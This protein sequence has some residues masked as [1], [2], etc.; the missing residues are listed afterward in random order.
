MRSLL[1]RLRPRLI[2]RAGMLLA[3][4]LLLGGCLIPPTPETTQAKDTYGLYLVV[5]I[6]GAIV[7][8]LVEGMLVWSII[9]YRRR[10]DRLPTQLHGNNLLEITWTVIPTIIV[11]VLF[12]LS[13]VTLGAIQKQAANPA[14]TI[15]V[16]AFQ[17]Q[18]TFHYL[19]GDTN[20]A[21]DYQVTG[22]PG[23]P[24]VMGVPVGEPIHL[25][26]H[27]V[28]VIHSFYV[29]HFLIKKDVI[30]FPA[31]QPDN[32]L[33]FTITQAGT[34]AGQCAEFCGAGHATMTFSI[35]AMSPADYQKWL[36]DAKA[37]NTPAPSASVAPG[38]TEINLSAKQIQFSTNNIQVPANQP[39]VVHFD[40]QD[41]GIAHNFSIVDAS[42]K[43]WFKGD[44]V[45]GPT[46]ID[47]SV[48]ALPAGSY[49]FLCDV[50]PTVMVGTLVAK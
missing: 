15:D 10:D 9:R 31:G 49:T 47:Y 35:L 42:G 24:P 29:P 13:T 25:D 36:A 17:W 43:V 6:M 41:Q 3:V 28:D 32:T 12:A 27:S 7:F 45:T 1:A 19:D 2:L 8:F 21:N 34:Y 20:P 26:L 4:A 39:F 16:T 18:W 40:N 33:D 44:I 30:P 11:L 38:Q 22:T 50:H 5:F 23:Q 14:V 37:G 48:P 46:K